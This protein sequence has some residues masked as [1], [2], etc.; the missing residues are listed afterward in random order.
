M[1]IA[2]HLFTIEPIKPLQVRRDP[3]LGRPVMAC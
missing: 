1:F 3:T 2:N